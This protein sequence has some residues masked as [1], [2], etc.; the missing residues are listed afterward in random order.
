MVWFGLVRFWLVI[1]LVVG[2]ID[3]SNRFFLLACWLVELVGWLVGCM[4]GNEYALSIYIPLLALL[5]F[6]MTP[7]HLSTTYIPYLSSYVHTQLPNC[8]PAC[9]PTCISR[10]MHTCVHKV[11]VCSYPVGRPRSLTSPPFLPH[12]I[13]LGLGLGLGYADA[14]K[15]ARADGACNAMQG[16]H[17]ARQTAADRQTDRQA[18]RHGDEAR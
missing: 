14:E 12:N 6:L 18:G 13:L 17:T 1:F 7:I 4:G 16:G 8:P 5:P 11:Y 15:G 2:S 9:L 3:R 10:R